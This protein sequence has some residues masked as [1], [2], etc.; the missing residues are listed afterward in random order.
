MMRRLPRWSGPIRRK[1]FFLL[2]LLLPLLVF[3]LSVGLALYFGPLVIRAAIEYGI[4]D[5]PNTPLKTHTTP[6]AYLG[7][8]IVFLPFLCTLALALPFDQRMLAV[9]LSASVVVS[10]GLVDDLGA[11]SPKEKLFGQL[12]AALLLI[13]AGVSIEISVVP[14]LAAQA[15][16]VL[17]L[18]TCMNA[19]NIVDVSDGLA[20]T[21]AIVGALAVTILAFIEQEL[22]LLIM[23]AA[24]MGSCS[25]FLFFNRQPAR[26]YLGDTGSMLLGSLLGTLC[27]LGTYGDNLFSSSFVPFCIMAI[28]FFDLA[29][30]MIARLFARLPL[31]QG[32]PDHFAVRMR[33]AGM[34]SNH[35][36]LIAGAFGLLFGA[37]GIL[38]AFVDD[39]TALLV[40]LSSLG[41]GIFLVVLV[42]RMFPAR[43]SPRFVKME[44]EAVETKVAKTKA[45]KGPSPNSVN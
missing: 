27:I 36:A 44:A 8:L 28:P 17:W 2:I 29:L 3:C 34:Q 37:I 19:F 5:K 10:V 35:I 30:V 22:P 41:L 18:L 14:P 11:L 15:L 13:K 26:V 23:G 31:M 38:S 21:S 7:G 39:A 33:D 45:K 24:L 4:T 40:S 20:T 42:M 32:S 43:T 1:H 16:T 25:G 12:I 9:L 6:V